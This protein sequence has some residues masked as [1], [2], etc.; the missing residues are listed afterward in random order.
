MEAVFG[1]GAHCV[2][3][4]DG[5]IVGGV[6]S[7][8]QASLSEV[9]VHQSVSVED[10]HL[11]D[12]GLAVRVHIEGKTA[13]VTGKGSSDVQVIPSVGEECRDIEFFPVVYVFVFVLLFVGHKTVVRGAMRRLGTHGVAKNA[14]LALF[15]NLVWVVILLR[16]VRQHELNSHH[17]IIRLTVV[18]CQQVLVVCRVVA[19]DY[20]AFVG[21]ERHLS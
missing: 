12:R 6:I 21:N 19:D 20:E 10:G 7:G 11:G 9:P 15:V 14:G 4:T 3:I 8:H 2:V 16:P 5:V 13:G 1:D 17:L 18:A